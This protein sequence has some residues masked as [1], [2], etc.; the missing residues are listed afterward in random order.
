MSDKYARDR[1]A[2]VA[3]AIL[4]V[5]KEWLSD[6]ELHVRITETLR[7]EFSDL[8]RQTLSENRPNPET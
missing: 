5:I 3:T 8:E 4:A 2:V 1:A 7:F 6:P